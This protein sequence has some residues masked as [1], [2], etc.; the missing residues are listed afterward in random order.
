[1]ILKKLQVCRSDNELANFYG[2]LGRRTFHVGQANLSGPTFCF[3]RL[4]V[5]QRVEWTKIYKAE[6]LDDETTHLK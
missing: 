4:C 1:M 5:W 3:E 2:N 6:F